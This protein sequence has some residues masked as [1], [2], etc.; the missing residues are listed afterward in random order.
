MLD[1][2]PVLDR[3]YL[4]LTEYPD[5]RS[6]DKALLDE[7]HWYWHK[8]TTFKEARGKH[9]VPQSKTIE[10]CRRIVQ[11]YCEELAGDPEV[12]ALR[13]SKEREFHYEIQ[14]QGREWAVAHG[15]A[16]T[17]MPRKVSTKRF[18]ILPKVEQNKI[19]KEWIKEYDKTTH[20]VP[21]GINY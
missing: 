21:L 13:R 2:T 20:E 7:Y 1:L 18:R 11:Q 19:D 17:L 12:M 9:N 4:I 14:R 15:R 8:I 10:R 3:V 6:D 5:A 16:V